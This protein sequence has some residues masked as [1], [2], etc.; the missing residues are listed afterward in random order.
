MLTAVYDDSGTHDDSGVVVMGGLIGNQAQWRKFEELWT[1]QLR[2]PI[3]GR[4]PIKRFHMTECVASTKTF[5]GYSRAESDNA[6]FNF[7]QIILSCGLYGSAIAV[8]KPAWDEHF[9]GIARDAIGDAERYCVSQCILKVR[10]FTRNA[11]ADAPVSLVLDNRPHRIKQHDLIFRL[12]EGQARELW[13]GVNFLNSDGFPPLQAADLWAWEVYTYAKDW[14]AGR[15]EPQR[16]HMLPFW[17]ADRFYIQIADRNAISQMAASLDLRAA[18][19]I[20]DALA[21]VGS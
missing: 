20:A 1:R 14:I 12:M 8:D 7:R 16:A 18:T 5:K 21:R 3:K 19:A 6:I 17:D 13:N 15:K 10:D 11:P 4:A 2:E 9:T